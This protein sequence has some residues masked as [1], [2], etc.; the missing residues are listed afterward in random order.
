MSTMAL[1]VQNAFLIR[2]RTPILTGIDLDLEQGS[3]W[4]VVGPNGSGKTSLLHLIAGLRRPTRGAVSIFGHPQPSRQARARI[5]YLTHEP[6]LYPYLTV[7]ENLE[8]CARLY[9]VQEAQPRYRQLL[10][11]L[12]ML[13]YLYNLP[14]HFSRG[15]LQ[16]VALARALLPRPVLLLLDEPFAGLDGTGRKIC[17]HL[18]D[19]YLSQGGTMMVAT[20]R[21]SE[22]PDVCQY[23]LTLRRGQVARTR[24][25]GEGPPGDLD[26]LSDTP[27]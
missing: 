21:S 8:L 10:R 4:L 6:L 7:Q 17:C 19:E 2:G 25:L 15:M 24:E 14:L 22:V 20:H 18:M 16:R 5:G 27:T 9:G 1:R 13:G 3:S 23:E 11:Q 12:G 26:D